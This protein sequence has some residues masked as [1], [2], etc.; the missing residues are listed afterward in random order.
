MLKN[1]SKKSKIKKEKS[2]IL[3]WMKAFKKPNA[4][5]DEALKQMYLSLTAENQ[6]K[7]DRHYKMVFSIYLTIALLCLI[8]TIGYSVFYLMIGGHNTIS[9]I[10]DFVFVA[11]SI[12][13]T[14]TSSSW[15]GAKPYQRILINM[16][17]M[18]RLYENQDNTLPTESQVVNKIVEEEK[19]TDK[20]TEAT[21]T[22]QSNENDDQTK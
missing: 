15:F 18:Q 8:A 16:D 6:K 2:M 11:L 3:F 17:Y 14:Y 1:I 21:K 19:Q 20:T 22:E 7:L 9:L 13:A 4:E 12:Y 10:A 5:Q